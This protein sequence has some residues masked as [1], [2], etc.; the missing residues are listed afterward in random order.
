[1]PY[2]TRLLLEDESIALDLRPHWWFFIGPVAAGIPVLA[3]LAGVLQLDGDAETAG[4]W[5]FAVVAALWAVWLV[6]RL[7]RWTTTH[8]VVTSDRL[9]YRS[10]VFAKHGRDIP[11]ERVNDIASF[12]TFF[13]RLLGSGD[14]LIESAGE[15]G[16]QTF[17]NIAHPDGVCQEI[18][19]QMEL[20]ATRAA[21]AGAPPVAPSV[22]AQIA[23]L[24]ALRDRGVISDA[25]FDAKKADLLK[26]M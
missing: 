2:P 3:L 7:L 18:Y 8:F 5:G 23:E 9:I 21:T 16:Q 20:N 11:L 17:S 24:A 15:R 13:E 22:P 4:L 12:Q 19:R 1:M 6:V 10:G 25:E 26:R 14:L